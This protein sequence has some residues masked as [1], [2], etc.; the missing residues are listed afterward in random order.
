MTSL[1]QCF[2]F[3]PFKLLLFLAESEVNGATVQT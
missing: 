2:V 1:A 3:F